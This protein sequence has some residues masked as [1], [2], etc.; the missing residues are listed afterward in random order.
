MHTKDRHTYRKDG[1]KILLMGRF[2]RPQGY[3][4]ALKGSAVVKAIHI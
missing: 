4:A 2:Y 1:K 3:T